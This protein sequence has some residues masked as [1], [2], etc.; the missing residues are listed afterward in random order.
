MEFVLSEF[1]RDTR[2]VGWLPC[3]DVTV[4]TEEL[5]ERAFLCLGE[6]GA[7]DDLLAGV[8]RD[9]V[10]MG[11]SNTGGA[12]LRV[13]G[14][15]RME[16]SFVS[17]PAL[18]LASAPSLSSSAAITASAI[19]LPSHS[20]SSAMSGSPWMLMTPFAPGIFIE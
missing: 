11:V 8:A 17:T 2:H 14:F 10:N 7:D 3:K 19:L 13:V 6:A 9:E 15:F 18:Y 4:L 16:G 1:P 12:E 20:H 5:G